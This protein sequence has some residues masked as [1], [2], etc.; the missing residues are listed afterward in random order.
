MQGGDAWVLLLQ[1]IVVGLARLPSAPD[2]ALAA[3]ASCGFSQQ[4]PPDPVLQPRG[5]NW[6]TR[7]RALP[8]AIRSRHDH[9]GRRCREQEET[10]VLCGSGESPQGILDNTPG[11]SRENAALPL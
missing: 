7:L 6:E 8:E 2:E 4:T 10:Q 1:R 5:G 11:Y 9:A 3:E